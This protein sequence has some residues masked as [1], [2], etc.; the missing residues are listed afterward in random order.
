MR[1]GPNRLMLHMYAYNRQATIHTRCDLASSSARVA[2]QQLPKCSP[3]VFIKTRVQYGVDGA[4]EVGQ[5]REGELQ[6]VADVVRWHLKA[7]E[8]ITA[9]SNFWHILQSI[10]IKVKTTLYKKDVH[11]VESMTVAYMLLVA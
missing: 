4:V 2:F 6:V 3:E 5:V 1:S 9:F 8:N 10:M 11:V 7:H